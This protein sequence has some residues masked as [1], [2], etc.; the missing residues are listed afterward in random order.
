MSTKT[1]G[2]VITF[3]SYKGGTGRTMLLANIAWILA[4]NGKRVLMIDWDLEAPG[5]HRYFHPFLDDPELNSSEGLIDFVTDFAIETVTPNSL[6]DSSSQDWYEPFTNILRYAVSIKYKFPQKGRLDFVPAGKQDNTYSARVNSFNWKNFYDRLGGGTFLNAVKSRICS[7]YDYVLIDSRTGTSDIS[8]ICTV[9]LPNLL[10]ICFTLNRQN[11]QG[12]SNIVASIREL[13][14]GNNIQIYPVPTR[15]EAGEKRKLDTA[16]DQARSQF[17]SCLSD[18]NIEQIETYWSDVEVPYRQYYAYEEVL[19]V[20]GDKPSEYN[21]ILASAERLTSF[22]TKKS[23]DKLVPIKDLI[24]RN[25]LTKFEWP[26]KDIPLAKDIHIEK[27]LRL[28]KELGITENDVKNFIKIIEQK[29]IPTKDWESTLRQ[30]AERHKEL[31]SRLYKLKTDDYPEIQELKLNAVEAINEGLHDIA[32]VYIDEALKKQIL[33]ESENLTREKLSH[34]KSNVSLLALTTSG[35]FRYFYW[36]FLVFFNRP[37]K[38]DLFKR[39]LTFIAI[40][41][42]PILSMFYVAI[43]LLINSPENLRF[44]IFIFTIV[45][46][47]IIIGI[48]TDL[49]PSCLIVL[50]VNVIQGSS[51]CQLHE[52]KSFSFFL[53]FSILLQAFLVIPSLDS[54]GRT[55]LSSLFS[56]VNQKKMF[57]W[58]SMIAFKCPKEISQFYREYLY[59][60]SCILLIFTFDI[61]S[62]IIISSYSTNNWSLNNIFINPSTTGFFIFI[63]SLSLIILNDITTDDLSGWGRNKFSNMKDNFNIVV[64]IYVLIIFYLLILYRF[65]ILILNNA[66]IIDDMSMLS[67]DFWSM[68]GE[69]VFLSIIFYYIFIIALKLREYPNYEIQ[70]TDNKI[71]DKNKGTAVFN[72]SINNQCDS[73]LLCKVESKYLLEFNHGA[74]KQIDCLPHSVTILSFIYDKALLKHAALNFGYIDVKISKRKYKHRLYASALHIKNEDDSANDISKRDNDISKRDKIIFDRFICIEKFTFDNRKAMTHI[75][76]VGLLNTTQKEYTLRVGN[77]VELDNKSIIVNFVMNG[78]RKQTI[79]IRSNEYLKEV[80][81]IRFTYEREKKY[82]NSQIVT[83]IEL[84]IDSVEKINLPYVIEIEPKIYNDTINR[85]TFEYPDGS[86]ETIDSGH[87]KSLIATD[88]PVKMNF[89][90]EPPIFHILTPG[91]TLLSNIDQSCDEPAK[92]FYAL[93]TIVGLKGSGKTTFLTSL[94]KEC[95]KDHSFATIIPDFIDKLSRDS[96]TE[97]HD[98]INNKLF[99]ANTPEEH[100]DSYDYQVYLKNKEYSIT[101]KDIAGEYFGSEHE[102]QNNRLCDIAKEYLKNTDFI[103]ITIDTK[104]KTWKGVDQQN[105]N[106]LINICEME[107]FNPKMLRIL[108]T[109]VDASNVSSDNIENWLYDKMPQTAAYLISII[110]IEKRQFYYIGIGYVENGAIIEYKPMQTVDPIIDII[111]CW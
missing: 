74:E 107:K 34:N 1:A 109:K 28:S 11:I 94:T 73:K 25:I 40:I 89:L 53:L 35:F 9:Q 2:N 50:V 10:V 111:K 56:K 60:L 18:L 83:S 84:Y 68:L 37:I 108:F 20:F 87:I 82:H 36:N 39:N 66:I 80:V 43:Q 102:Q 90:N 62:E 55:Q 7:D 98:A 106:L 88:V 26:T 71:I 95:P 13:Q 78:K 79:N 69:I 46:I 32:N 27:Y 97:N 24:R 49:G 92:G 45:S 86:F 105:L 38:P 96:F 33:I 15:I 31:L 23:V 6:N 93:I 16:R 12:A 52:S 17:S 5:L 42:L 47:T 41:S 103:L 100:F 72:F 99:P 59:I 4:S 8:G 14:V 85:V 57:K 30:L 76:K 65:Y 22:L 19:A 3:Y 70:F 21:T 91:L 29:K 54:F 51:L 81:E 61:H 58:Y 64:S 67:V 77:K 101:I 44:I 110:R 48:R 104:P 63:I 75:C